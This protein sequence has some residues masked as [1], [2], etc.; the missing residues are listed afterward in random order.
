MTKCVAC[1]SNDVVK[2]KND[3]G[4]V[5][6]E[7]HKPRRMYH[8]VCNACGYVAQYVEVVKT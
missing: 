2:A 1:Q 8:H 7:K 4:F 5:K 6:T 3:S